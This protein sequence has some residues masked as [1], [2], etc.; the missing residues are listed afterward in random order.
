MALGV[1]IP[2]ILSLNSV[3]MIYMGVGGQRGMDKGRGLGGGIGEP[4][5]QN[6]D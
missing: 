3:P 2:C 4:R 6:S 1:L 5:S